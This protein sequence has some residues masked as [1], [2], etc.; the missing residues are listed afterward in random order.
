MRR[1]GER[2]T[3]KDIQLIC[4]RYTLGSP[5]EVLKCASALAPNP[6][7][8]TIVGMMRGTN[9]NYDENTCWENG[10]C[11]LLVDESLFENQPNS[12]LPESSQQQGE[13]YKDIESAAGAHIDW[14]AKFDALPEK[15]K[16]A[17]RA[18]AEKKISSH[19]AK[20]KPD[21]YAETLKLATFGVFQEW[22]R[23]TAGR[24]ERRS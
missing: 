14:Q 22:S 16:T 12:P 13:L 7:I 11:A 9:G 5:R 19:K 24:T 8:K 21:V 2:I 6:N 23:S 15:D 4:K 20:M 18:Q 3:A 10:K 1:T 17:I